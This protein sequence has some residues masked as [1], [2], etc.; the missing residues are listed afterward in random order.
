VALGQ[1]PPKVHSYQLRLFKNTSAFEASALT[2]LPLILL[3]FQSSYAHLYSTVSV[4]QT[5]H[6]TFTDIDSRQLFLNTY[7]F[8]CRVPEKKLHAA[9]NIITKQ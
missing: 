9:Y 1:N 3:I 2:F 4:C 5:C 8:K 6:V 7:G